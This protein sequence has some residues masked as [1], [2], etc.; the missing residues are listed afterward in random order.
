MGIFDSPKYLREQMMK[1]REMMGNK[2]DWELSDDGVN[3][4][5]DMAFNGL[6]HAYLEIKKNKIDS[7]KLHMDAIMI[8]FG[9]RKL[10]V[11]IGS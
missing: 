5:I 4:K 11:E 10:Y 7:D 2:P 1:F 8:E 3:R 6:F 9:R